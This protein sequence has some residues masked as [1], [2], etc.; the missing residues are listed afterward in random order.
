MSPRR[1]EYSEAVS[2][3]QA[4]L[5]LKTDRGRADTYKCE[6]CGGSAAE[7]AYKGGCPNE[8]ADTRGKKYSLDQSRY[9]PMCHVCHR[10]SDRA[11]ADGRSVETCPKGHEWTLENT[12][13]RVKRAANTGLRFCK[14]CNREHARRY[15]LRLLE[16][17]RAA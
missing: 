6:T 1:H 11:L 12:G 14:A 15:R 9:A 17:E 4:H 8:L 5:R 7:W 2:Y 16:S 10:R 3:S 13:I